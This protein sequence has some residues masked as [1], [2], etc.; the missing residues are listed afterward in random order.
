MQHY[1]HCDV[2]FQRI[3]DVAIWKS[4]HLLD[5]ILI[6]L[7][8]LYGKSGKLCNENALLAMHL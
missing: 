2:R 3:V 5:E 6:F 4:D 7:P 8:A 1:V